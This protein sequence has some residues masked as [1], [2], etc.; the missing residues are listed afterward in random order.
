MNRMSTI[1]IVVCLAGGVFHF[2]KS[3]DKKIEVHKEI[4]TPNLQT[5]IDTKNAPDLKENSIDYS[6]VTDW[7][8]VSPE[9]LLY[10][11]HG[12]HWEE[13]FH[14]R[15]PLAYIG[16][17]SRGCVSQKWHALSP[18]ELVALAKQTD[19][20][21]MTTLHYVAAVGQV[22]NP[23]S[24]IS[25]LLQ[26]GANVNAKSNTGKTPLIYAAQSFN[27]QAVSMFLKSGA[28][29]NEQDNH[30][31]TALMFA[32]KHGINGKSMIR[33]LLLAGADKYQSTY[34]GHIGDME[35]GDFTYEKSVNAIDIAQDIN[36]I[37]ILEIL[38]Q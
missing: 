1:I 16:G 29:V 28:S 35:P 22:G 34:G 25:K 18:K 9:D 36:N 37:E 14:G 2:L 13:K 3:T 38:K 26:G 10:R 5:S 30:G 19:S 23:E 24:C 12:Q 4:A 21:G 27:W 20:F 31:R 6:S 17:G 7:Y 8:S 11:L 32:V 15:S 33:D